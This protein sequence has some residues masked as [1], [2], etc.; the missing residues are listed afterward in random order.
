[1][2]GAEVTGFWWPAGWKGRKSQGRL[3]TEGSALTLALTE[4]FD[5]ASHNSDVDVLV[6][7]VDESGGRHSLLGCFW[8]SRATSTGLPASPERWHV[9]AHLAGVHLSSP[10]EP[11]VSMR[12]DI[13]S[14]LSWSGLGPLAVSGSGGSVGVSGERQ[15]LDVGV[16]DG[17]RIELFVDH[18]L[19][20]NGD[21]V[22]VARS[23]HFD[24]TPGVEHQVTIQQA[25]ARFATPL[26]DL[27]ILLTNHAAR[28]EPLHF[29]FGADNGGRPRGAVYHAP[30]LDDDVPVV[31]ADR[32][33]MLAP[34][35]IAAMDFSDLMAAWFKLHDRLGYA[36]TMVNVPLAVPHQ[37]GETLVLTASLA[38]ERLHRELC[39]PHAEDP[40]VHQHRKAEILASAPPEYRDW[41]RARLGSNERG[42]R[43]KV[44]DIVELASS[45][46]LA[47]TD[48]YP[49]FAKSLAGARNGVAHATDFRE[50]D[51]ERY[52]YLSEPARWIAR[53]VL[54]LQLGLADEVVT[55]L[56]ERNPQFQDDLR[57]LERMNQLA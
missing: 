51:G 53:H 43:R 4:W 18:L 8:T 28:L 2:L 15:S 45:T 38:L 49:Q 29:T 5:P 24:V 6:H 41:L 17:A 30:R 13:P 1:V 42:F 9:D 19:T 22:T 40:V 47:V 56:I 31:A 39:D 12:V 16:V 23:A 11:V 50:S 21:S 52:L 55:T 34:W 26:D 7:G 33:K 36:V 3:S 27:V 37:L 35:P 57:L 32:R 20:A 54:L 25:I 10:D 46:G 48:A 44:H 14:L